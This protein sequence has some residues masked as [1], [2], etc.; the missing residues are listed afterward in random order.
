M[1][2]ILITGGSGFIGAHV[3]KALVNRG[4]K[5]VVYGRATKG[6]GLRNL[7]E[8]SNK[9]EIVKG[10]VLDSELLRKSVEKFGVEKIVHTAAL[11]GHFTSIERPTQ[12]VKVNTLGTLNV[13]ETARAMELKRV[14]DFSTQCVYGPFKYEPVDEDHPHEPVSPYGI[15]KLANELLGLAYHRCYGVDYMAVRTTFVYGPGMPEEWDELRT[16]PPA[17]FIKSA[18]E[19]KPL[20]MEEGGDQ[21][22][23]HI[24]VKDLVQGVLLMLD[25]KEPKHRI[26]NITS[27]KAYT[28]RQTAEMVKQLAPGTSIEV[29]PGLWK[30]AMG[31]EGAVSTRR[32]H[33]E[34]GYTPKYD[35]QDGLREYLEWYKKA[36]TAPKGD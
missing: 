32:A 19:R 23:D 16:R 35:L 20:K 34:L 22:I 18:V 5:V 36:R 7:K 15:T 3:A 2:V 26:Y 13:L 21:K 17:T 6:Y 1:A 29:G 27:G 11:I 25:V 31:Q 33:E 24:Y 28:L 12:T 10:D 14:L 8:I 4:D 30:Y 9:I